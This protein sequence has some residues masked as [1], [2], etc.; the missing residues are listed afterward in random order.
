MGQ[1][2]WQESTALPGTIPRLEVPRS[3]TPLSLWDWKVWSQARPTLWRYGDAG[4][5]D[6]KRSVPLLV[7]EW[8]TSLCLREEM[9][10]DLDTDKEPFPRAF[11]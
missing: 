1:Q 5:L 7:H 11:Q 10:Y 8:I 4:N 3:S 2:T 9:E 6:P